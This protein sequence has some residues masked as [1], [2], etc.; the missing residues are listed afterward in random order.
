MSSRN[1]SMIIRVN[2]NNKYISDDAPINLTNIGK[3]LWQKEIFV[4]WPHLTEA[5]V[6]AVCTQD[7]L[8]HEGAIQKG[9]IKVFDIQAR[10]LSSQ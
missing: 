10:A 6:I 2:T 5:K 7:I 8:F 3:S 4:G 9:D 1:E